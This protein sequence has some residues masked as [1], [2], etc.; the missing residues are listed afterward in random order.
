MWWIFPSVGAFAA[1]DPWRTACE[2]AAGTGVR[3]GAAARAGEGWTVVCDGHRWTVDQL[4]GDDQARIELLWVL[5]AAARSHDGALG[6]PPPPAHAAPSRDRPL[7]VPRPPEP[8]KPA[9]PTPPA[10]AQPEAP[11]PVVT[12]PVPPP[13]TPISAAE[14]ELP[15]DFT[16]PPLAAGVPQEP[17]PPEPPP[18]RRTELALGGWSALGPEVG[19]RRSAAV[20]LQLPRGS[21]RV[22]IGR[23]GPIVPG[24]PGFLGTV[25][26]S[27]G[28][29]VEWGWVR[30]GWSG[31]ASVRTTHG[32]G[33][34]A[35][36]VIP[37]ISTDALLSVPL[38]RVVRLYVGGHGEA[39]LRET[40]VAAPTPYHA[41]RVA[42][43]IGAGL[44]VQVG[45]VR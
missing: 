14:R 15:D 12:G 40:I 44:L 2:R 10:P 5:L 42:L 22:A 38:S 13:P 37:A 19:A 6:L 26:L 31:V 23:T 39:D 4:P 1:D 35:W 43:G 9:E 24:E 25:D 18:P 21:A 27:L 3:D 29:A 16:V 33:P 7:P 34:S 30:V 11:P 36:T 8:A 41:S 32:A 17:A 45:P 28:P 20:E